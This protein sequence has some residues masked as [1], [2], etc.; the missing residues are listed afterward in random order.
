MLSG[1]R[2][3]NYLMALLLAATLMAGS[4]MAQGKGKSV[5]FTGQ[6]TDFMCGAKHTMM[7]GTPEKECTMTCVKMGSKYG[8]AVAD[9]VYELEGKE[10]ELEKFAGA[11]AKV[12]GTL[13]GT[14]I[15]VTAVSAP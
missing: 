2:K 1:K 6:V 13:D 11:K 7:P 9:K 3:W 14:K 5:T 8:L 4:G 15:Q 12:T 10:A